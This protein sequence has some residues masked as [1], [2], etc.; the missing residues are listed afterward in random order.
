M[1]II[2]RHLAILSL[3][4]L[5]VLQTNQ[6][7]NFK[8]FG[9]NQNLCFAKRIL[10]NRNNKYYSQCIG[11]GKKACKNSC[12]NLIFEVLDVLYEG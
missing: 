3:Y 1:A 10:N 12:K 7:M 8:I 4:G 2:T 6:F 5:L 11:Y 9:R